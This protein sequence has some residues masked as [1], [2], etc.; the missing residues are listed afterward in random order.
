M[1]SSKL[2]PLQRRLYDHIV[3]DANT[4]CG[5]DGIRISALVLH[6]KA[7]MQQVEEALHVLQ[8]MKLIERMNIIFGSDSR[9]R[10]SSE[11]TP[12]QFN[13]I[14]DVLVNSIQLAV[15]NAKSKEQKAQLIMII[16]QAKDDILHTQQ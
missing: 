14:H 7:Q 4:R 15:L 6:T 13:M 1:S 16:E 5:N 3:A 9:W 8:D 11:R 10:L 2:A 12:T